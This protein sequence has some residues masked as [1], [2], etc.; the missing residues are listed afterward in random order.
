[1]HAEV[2]PQS[3]R[4]LSLVLIARAVLLLQRGHPQTYAQM[5]LLILAYRGHG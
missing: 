5:R 2:L 1:M 4:V 3:T